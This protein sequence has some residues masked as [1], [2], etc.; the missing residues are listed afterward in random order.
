MSYEHVPIIETFTGTQEFY[1]SYHHRNFCFCGTFH[2]TNS[3]TL[4][5]TTA[6][7]TI[8]QDLYTS[9][10]Q[11]NF[12]SN[13]ETVG[14]FPLEEHLQ[15]LR[16]FFCIFP[17]ENLTETLEVKSHFHYRNFKGTVGM[18]LPKKH[19]QQL[20]KCSSVYASTAQTFTGTQEL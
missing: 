1:A 8:S 18:F 10:R 17:L 9:F 15:E 6:P 13:P 12:Y 4:G 14:I 11:R 7:F 3:G 5:T 16:N 20:L 19:S 2:T